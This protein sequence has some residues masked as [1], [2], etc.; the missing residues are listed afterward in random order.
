VRGTITSF[1]N[2]VTGST[3][4]P[5]RL[6]VPQASEARSRSFGL[7]STSTWGPA[8]LDDQLIAS[9]EPVSGT[10]TRSNPLY[11]IGSQYYLATQFRFRADDGFEFFFGGY[12]LLN[13]E[14]PF[15]AEI[16]AVAGQD[17]DRRLRSVRAAL[18]C[19]R[20]SRLLTRSA[21][22]LGGKD[23]ASPMLQL[24]SMRP[25]Q[26]IF[27]LAQLLCRATRE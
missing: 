4:L 19:W 15:L 25:C 12:N 26:R 5:I 18:R 1:G 13:N 14:P 2:E 24:R 11:R 22:K 7:T 8:T 23:A 27:E 9:D 17:T 16:G 3:S 21:D 6:V 10:D 20:S